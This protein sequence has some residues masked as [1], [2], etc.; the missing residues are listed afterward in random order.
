M[1]VSSSC[2]E[3]CSRWHSRERVLRGIY[4]EVSPDVACSA[5]ALL[6]RLGKPPLEMITGVKQFTYSFSVFVF[7][8]NSFP[9]RGC[10]PGLI[11]EAE[12]AQGGRNHCCRICKVPQEFPDDLRKASCFLNS[13]DP[14]RLPSLSPT[15]S[16]LLLCHLKFTGIKLLF[17]WSWVGS[18]GT[19]FICIYFKADSRWKDTDSKVFEAGGGRVPFWCLQGEPPSQVLLPRHQLPVSPAAWSPQPGT[20]SWTLGMCRFCP[21]FSLSQRID[22]N[23]L[24]TRGNLRHFFLFF[25]YFPNPCSITYGKFWSKGVKFLCWLFNLKTTAPNTQGTLVIIR[26]LQPFSNTE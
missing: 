11:G 23:H 2:A 1:P 15:C 4:R 16:L 17:R 8:F 14:T 19:A 6:S 9:T 25:I 7:I 5:G 21:N 22:L 18:G 13:R 12:T 24:T 3:R 10:L 20:F 26:C